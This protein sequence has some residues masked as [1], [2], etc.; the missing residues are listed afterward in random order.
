MGIKEREDAYRKKHSLTWEQL[1]E[2]LEEETGYPC[3]HGTYNGW[4]YAKEFPVQAEGVFG[5]W[6]KR[7]SKRGPL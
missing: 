2:K 4:L 7:S 6:C 1:F 3:P 5:K